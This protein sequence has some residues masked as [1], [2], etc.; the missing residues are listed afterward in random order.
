PSCACIVA[1]GGSNTLSKIRV[2]RCSQSDAGRVCRRRPERPHADRAIGHLKS[3]Q[4]N[5]WNCPRIEV[6]HTTNQLQFVIQRHFRQQSVDPLLDG[7]G[8]RGGSLRKSDD[9]T[10]DECPSENIVLRTHG[11][12]PEM[13]PPWAVGYGQFAVAMLPPGVID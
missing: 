2:P 11:S 7:R 5:R 10:E 3:L 13:I 6:I 1:Q 12:T 4:P 9:S 8:E